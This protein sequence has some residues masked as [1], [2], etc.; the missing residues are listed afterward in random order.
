MGTHRKT[1]A[2]SGTGPPTARA[3]KPPATWFRPPRTGWPAAVGV[4]GRDQHEQAQVRWRAWP[5]VRGRDGPDPHAGAVSFADTREAHRLCEHALG[6][7]VHLRR[8]MDSVIVGHAPQERV[9]QHVGREIK[10]SS[11]SICA[12]AC[13]RAHSSPS[14]TEN[15]SR[16]NGFRAVRC[17][18]IRSK[19]SISRPGR[20]VF[21]CCRRGP[22]GRR[23]KRVA[24]SP[25]CR[26]AGHR[27]AGASR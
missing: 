27:E 10:A 12:Q 3:R 1:C 4:N 13:P 17:P 19:G 25:R 9:T 8:R 24:P 6:R 22:G 18:R 5:P 16:T 11:S 14:A 7:Q 2:K 21:P 23:W 15:L 26:P 20:S